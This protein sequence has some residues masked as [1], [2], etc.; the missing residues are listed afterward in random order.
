LQIQIQGGEKCPKNTPPKFFPRVVVLAKTFEQNFSKKC[1][2]ADVSR[3][4]GELVV[5]IWDQ[6][7]MIRVSLYQINPKSF[8]YSDLAVTSIYQHP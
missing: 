4:E 6:S 5:Q 8:V 1:A 2:C 7:G 3:L